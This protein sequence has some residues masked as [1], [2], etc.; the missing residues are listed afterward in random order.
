MKD[1]PTLPKGLSDLEDEEEPES[2]GG[3]MEEPLEGEPD[4]DLLGPPLQIP[5]DVTIKKGG[6][7]LRW[8]GQLRPMLSLWHGLRV[9]A[10]LAK[11]T[12]AFDTLISVHLHFE[13]RL[14]ISS[15]TLNISVAG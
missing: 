10:L 9:N 6:D 2:T 7:S 1:F 11:F 14:R 3:Q 4:D 12:Q 13:L 8:G 15:V 5:F